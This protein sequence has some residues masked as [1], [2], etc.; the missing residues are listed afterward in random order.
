MGWIETIGFGLF[1]WDQAIRGPSELF[2]ACTLDASTNSDGKAMI[3]KMKRRNGG[4]QE[5]E[6]DGRKIAQL[7]A[8][9][10]RKSV[11]GH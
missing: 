3:I 5:E 4:A 1:V 11:V 9:R 2:W 8:G 7:R 10:Q 6:E